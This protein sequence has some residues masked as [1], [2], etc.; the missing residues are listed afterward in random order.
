MLYL[1]FFFFFPNKSPSDTTV[2]EHE[3]TVMEDSNLDNQKILS[4][5]SAPEIE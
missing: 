2:P 1:F 3:F 4:T 5:Q